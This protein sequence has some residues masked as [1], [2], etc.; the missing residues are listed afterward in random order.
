MLVPL[1]AVP[2]PHLA[3]VLALRYLAVYTG[4]TLAAYRHDLGD[5][6]AWCETHEVAPLDATRSVVDLYVHD[7]GA[8]SSA[9]PSSSPSPEEVTA[10]GSAAEPS[11]AAPRRPLAP[12][13]IA[14]RLVAISGFYAYAVDEGILE[15]NP[16][17]RVRRPRQP[18]DSP[19]LGLDRREARRLLDA[20]AD[21]SP[22]AAALVS[23]LLHCGLRISE[24]LSADV[25]DLATVHGHRVLGVTRK[26]GAR[27]NIVLPAPV[28]RVLDTYL[29]D[30]GRP[31]GPLFD[32]RTGGRYDRAEA[33]RLIQRLADDAG[34]SSGISPHSL[35]H[36]FVTL[37]R[38]AGVALE[39]V[40][41]A[42]GHADPRTTR[43]Y[44]R[45]R[46]SLDRS[47]AHALGGY[48]AG[49]GEQ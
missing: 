45:G 16:T 49:P 36:T 37:A 26:G 39:D 23:V 42:A 4:H 21:H 19:T 25:T 41:D 48:L 10:V 9:S 20:A 15:R 27:R 3:E 44:D 38:E 12:A 32:T 35:R 33:W 29:A 6:F 11:R 5:Y 40:Q 18:Q 47:P 30:R 17:T 14:R 13:T 8:G 22:R 46:F 24:A 2:T 31:V 1:E 28:C 34:I 7:L 43:R